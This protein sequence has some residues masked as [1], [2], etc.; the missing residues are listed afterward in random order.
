MERERVSTPPES[1]LS[2]GLSVALRKRGSFEVRKPVRA[3]AGLGRRA[4]PR[5]DPA[6]SGL[7]ARPVWLAE[8]RRNPQFP[9]RPAAGV[10]AGLWWA[11]VTTTGVGY[12][13]KVPITLRGRLLAGVWMLVSLVLSVLVTASLTATLAIAEFQQVRDLESL[14]RARVGVLKG[15]A[16]ADFLR[17]NQI[18]HRSFRAPEGHETLLARHRRGLFNGDPALLPIPPPAPA[19]GAAAALHAGASGSR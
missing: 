14:R 18:P 8:R 3:S 9:A 15:S 1:Y 19:A 16:A 5:R 17:H 2:S 7:P 13:D 10:G 12:G 4:R 6:L 11:G